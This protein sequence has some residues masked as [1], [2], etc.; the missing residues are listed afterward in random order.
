MSE[1]RTLSKKHNEDQKMLV[2]EYWKQKK[3]A[4]IK[5]VAKVLS[6]TSE[7]MVLP[8]TKMENPGG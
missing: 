1:R 3:D 8:T 4:G 7:E 6:P 2:L 5:S